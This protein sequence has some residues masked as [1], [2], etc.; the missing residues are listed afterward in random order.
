MIA[1]SK[2]IKIFPLVAAG[3]IALL[4]YLSVKRPDLFGESTLLALLVLVVVGFI[5]SQFE[6]YFLTVM[7]VIF[8]WA[9]SSVPLAGAMAIFRWV[10]LGLGALLAPVYYARRT[11]RISFDYVHLLGLF[12]VVTAFSSAL[13][14]V[15]PVI[16]VLKALSVAG[17]FVYS[18]IGARIFWSRD[19]ELFVRRLILMVEVMVYFTAIC[20]L[21]S[22]S[23]WG[24]PNSLGLIM[25]CICWPVLLWRLILPADRQEYPRRLASVLVCAGLLILSLSRASMM[26]AFVISLFLLLGA[27]RY[28]TLL[29]GISLFLAILLNLFL[30]MPERFQSASET[31]LYKHGEH[32]ESAHL[33]ETREKP[34]ERSLA[35]FRQHPWLGLGFGAADNSTD[36]RL[37]Y[38]TQGYYTRERGS[39]Y[40]TI[41]ETI[42]VLGAV[43]CALLLL[44]L[45]REIWKVFS[46]LRRSGEVNQPAVV[47]AAIL[48][49]GLVSASFEDWMF[50]VGYYMSVI[51]WLL[52]FSLRDWMDCPAWSDAAETERPRAFVQSSFALRGR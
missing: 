9:G 45:I 6:T 14:S 13:V 47:A 27:R 11:N 12:V 21:L 38:E 40:L 44:C 15:N 26:A 36:R 29:M 33:M 5:A 19:P 42:G 18:S 22:F 39:S 49:G 37:T 2:S 35:T 51:F 52:A 28:R 20:Y 24:N 7:V 3:S 8:F 32:G 16:T 46:R 30:L 50:A 31:L 4:F 10:V 41:L 48:L 17:L 43:P 34:W 1:N 25:G 23:V